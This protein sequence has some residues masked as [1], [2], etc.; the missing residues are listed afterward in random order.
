[1][2]TI[3]LQQLASLAGFDP[4][5]L[6]HCRDKLPTASAVHTGKPGRP[7]KAFDIADLADFALSHTNDLSDAECRLVVAIRRV[8]TTAKEP[9]P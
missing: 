7:V 5:H 9:R 3:S 2:D 8:A 1:M 4:S 6:V